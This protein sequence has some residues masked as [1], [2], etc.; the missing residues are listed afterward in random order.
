[1][2]DPRHYKPWHHLRDVALA[3][4]V[5]AADAHLLERV[6]Q[7]ADARGWPPELAERLGWGLPS[8]TT[9]LHSL[10]NAA[11]VRAFQASP[12]A[13]RAILRWLLGDQPEPETP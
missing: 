9:L 8:D 12:R 10:D 7:Q 2:A 13:Y 5:G 3:A 4:G 1:V 11:L 6:M